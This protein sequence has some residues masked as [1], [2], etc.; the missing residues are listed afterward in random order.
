[1]PGQ[2]A[3]TPRTT[4][5]SRGLR[6]TTDSCLGDSARVSRRRSSS[7]I[8][9]RTTNFVRALST[10]ANP[11][12]PASRAQF[13]QPSPP[14]ATTAL[15]AVSKEQA[16]AATPS[17][18]LRAVDRRPIY[19]P[20]VVLAPATPYAHAPLPSSSSPPEHPRVTAI[21]IGR[22]NAS[23]RTPSRFT[24]Y[25][26][27]F[28]D[29]SPS[30]SPPRAPKSPGSE[31][32][33][34][35]Q[36]REQEGDGK[37]ARELWIALR[38]D[39]Y[40][41]GCWCGPP[42]IYNSREEAE[43]A[44]GHLRFYLAGSKNKNL[45]VLQKKDDFRWHCNCG[46]KDYH[47]VY[48][49]LI[50]FNGKRS[51]E[52]IGIDLISRNQDSERSKSAKSAK[53][54]DRVIPAS[55]EPS[56][57]E[58]EQS[59]AITLAGI[60]APSQSMWA[61]ACGIISRAVLTMGSPLMTVFGT[62]REQ[63]YSDAYEALDTRQQDA[64]N[65]TIT[66]KRLKRQVP[67]QPTE[68]STSEPADDAF[69][70][71]VWTDD[72]TKRIGF[73]NLQRLADVL[74]T[75]YECVKNNAIMLAPSIAA[76][77]TEIQEGQ[78]VAT[79][80]GVHKYREYMFGPMLLEESDEEKAEKWMDTMK[81]YQQH[82]GCCI[83]LIQQIYNQDQ[84]EELK[85]N[86]PA[87]PRRLP[88]GSPTF[89]LTARVV[90]V[91]LSFIRSL[92]TVCTIDTPTLE[93]ISQ[94]IVDANA[95]HKQEMLPS[96]VEQKRDPTE[97]MPGHFPEDKTSAIEQIPAD[98]F[99]IPL[100]YDLKFPEPETSNWQPQTRFG[101]YKL[102]PE[103]KGILKPSKEWHV[104]TSP[105]YV[106][107][108]EKK[109]K[110]SF[111]NPVHK[112]IPP[113]HIPSRIMTPEE[114]ARIVEPKFQADIIG[115]EHSIRIFEAARTVDRHGN[116]SLNF[117]DRFN[118]EALERDDKEMGLTY[119]AKKYDGFLNDL[120]DDMLKRAEE[121]KENRTKTNLKLTPRRRMVQIPLPPL[122]STPEMRQRRAHLF[123]DDTNSPATSSPGINPLMRAKAEEQLPKPAQK[124]PGPSSLEEFFAQDDDLE[125]Q[126]DIST[127]KFE[128]LQIDRQ[129]KEELES[130]ALRSAEEKRKRAEEEARRQQERRFEEERRKREEERRR[131]QEARRQ[132]EAEEF[133]ALTGLRRPTR[134]LITPLPSDWDLR[135]SSAANANPQTELV[136][137]LEGQPLTRRDFEEKLLP[138]TAWLN[139]N[140]IIG[141]ILHI[142]DYINKAKGA[143]DQE[144][145]CAAFTSYFW[146]R[147][148]SNGAGACGRLL[149]RA[150]VRKANFLNIDTILIPI[151]AQS[152]WTLAVIRPDKR[153]VAHIDSMR[154]G[155]G[156]ESVKTKL[157]ELVRFI[158]E[159]KFVEA[160]WSAVD[161]EGPRQTNGWDCGVF[162]VTNA[163]C[164]ALGLNPRFTYTERELTLQR[165]RLA[166]MLLNEGF[167]GD[168][169]LDGF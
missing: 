152:H 168:F 150:G 20:P 107:T 164:M 157:L 43:T 69:D 104:P 90:G 36:R 132:R 1:M 72:P 120:Q 125:L 99:D 6:F 78:D 47:A 53:S 58:E 38:N 169:S 50:N 44:V 52:D 143:I 73:K 89:R 46:N 9:T 139:D 79:S 30:I 75:Q 87:P 103:R 66:V 61:Q 34:F 42:N 57:D 26:T 5:N 40:M 18:S 15:E 140:V 127:R 3:S 86:Y 56:P 49:N 27:K 116:P 117:E 156:D 163:M 167:K 12:T 108:P 80:I 91:F 136:K 151:C 154:G 147:L 65:G 7:G 100:L 123:A 81:V 98:E 166:A 17:P 41:R 37:F 131:E 55:I 21:R 13:V 35:K 60:P 119:H 97:N 111:I 153:T 71:L 144:P 105:K 14:S 64:D 23:P 148:L 95:I 31:T 146:P 83:E 10:W 161:Y 8:P 149:R 94:M 70:N 67:V 118:L 102:V 106:A 54:V 158:L 145:K 142:A 130:A 59:Q 109:K 121:D 62:L 39:S 28:I 85:R 137:T 96:F 16:Q 113:T 68:Q 25:I 124:K 82:L 133:A 45:R 138:P 141:S 51:A 126:L 128:Q 160:D 115:D 29:A 165:R 48:Q 63:L 129:I 159:D 134:P 2:A 84:L 33:L 11:A 32:R 101:Y 114:A 92:N 110:L 4:R 22:R 76:I 19:P 122:P 93:A 77:R 162:T 155:R 135:V 24:R 74:V 112:F 88:L